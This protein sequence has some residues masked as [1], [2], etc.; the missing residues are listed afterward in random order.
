MSTVFRILHEACVWSDTLGFRIIVYIV[1]WPHG[2]RVLFTELL[3]HLWQRHMKCAVTNTCGKR[4]RK[5]VVTNS[6]VH[7][8][9]CELLLLLLVLHV[10]VHVGFEHY[11]KGAL[12]S[13]HLQVQPSCFC[14]ITPIVIIRPSI[15]YSTSL[16]AYFCISF[17]VVWIELYFLL[18]NIFVTYTFCSCTSDLTWSPQWL[19]VYPLPRPLNKCSW[20][21]YL[22]TCSH[23]NHC[24]HC[25]V[26]WPLLCVIFV[27]CIH[28]RQDNLSGK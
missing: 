26:L 8:C 21:C 1:V 13:L 12:C 27:I 2:N 25:L 15:V 7:T 18:C 10:P 11:L 16:H 5:C 28:V 3:S 14:S 24:I 22:A 19:N 4:D 17:E 20:Y 6:A 23:L 9:H